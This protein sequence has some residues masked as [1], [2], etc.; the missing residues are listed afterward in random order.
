MDPNR[1][2]KTPALNRRQVPGDNTKRE[3][4]LAKDGYERLDGG[5]RTRDQS[6]FSTDREG[7]SEPV[8]QQPRHYDDF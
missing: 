6:P 3:P 4:S 7:L 8:Y 5:P 2:T 1:I